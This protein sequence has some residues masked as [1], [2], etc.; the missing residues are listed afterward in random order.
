MSSNFIEIV[1]DPSFEEKVSMSRFA[2]IIEPVNI[3]VE[4][5]AVVAI[6][7]GLFYIYKKLDKAKI[8]KRSKR[9]TSGEYAMTKTE[10]EKL[11]K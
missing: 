1:E 5:L 2:E 3:I 9:H 6:A 4:S 10:Q 7:V 8:L 11:K